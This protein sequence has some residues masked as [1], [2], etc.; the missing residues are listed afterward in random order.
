MDQPFAPP[1]ADLLLLAPIAGGALHWGTLHLVDGAP[2]KAGEAIAFLAGSVA[3]A[4]WAGVTTPPESAAATCLLGWTLLALTLA[5][6]RA[7]LLPDA[8]T[9]PLA[10]AGLVLAAPERLPHCVAGMA[11]GWL[12]FAAIAWGYR[13]LRGRDG[14]GLG[15]AK[16]MAAAGAWVG[17]EGLPGTVVVAAS[18][19]L[20]WAVA[21]GLL[22]AHTD[23][24]RRIPFGP[25]LAAGLWLT[26]TLGPI[27]V[28]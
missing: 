23:P 17:W 9:M 3:V 15:D 5:D 8:L 13:R 27:H 1:A 20:A 18:L 11:A 25:S 12:S 16:L 19:G 22:R 6:L 2:A 26:W 24:S 28:A 7:L 10:A 14:L 4:L 21:E